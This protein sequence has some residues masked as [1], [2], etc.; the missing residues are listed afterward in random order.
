MK[1]KTSLMEQ[2]QSIKCEHLDEVL[3][4]RLGDFYEMFDEDAIEVSRLLNLTL[5]HR[6]DSPMCGV[7]HHAS[8][9]YI[10]RLLRLGKKIAICEQISLPKGGIG[11]AERKVTEIITPGTVLEEEYLD[12]GNHNFLAAVCLIKKMVSWAYIDISTGDFFATTW[13]NSDNCS[14]LEKELGRINPRE[15][16]ISK[17][18][19]EN[20]KVQQIIEQ[21][22]NVSISREDDWHFNF[23][24]SNQAL[25]K[26]FGTVNLRSFGLTESSTEA[27]AAGYLLEY[28]S[29]N[30]SYS[31]ATKI[32]PQVT[33]LSVYSDSDY[34]IIDDS[35]RRNLELTSNL[36]DGTIHYS[37]LE[38]VEY[39][40]TAMGKRMLRSFFMRPLK[41]I[42]QIKKRQQHI[43]LFIQNSRML[44]TIRNE[45]SKILD[46]ERLAGRIAM[47]RA[48]AKDIQAL[49]ISLE[50][51]IEMRRIILDFTGEFGNAFFAGEIDTAQLICTTIEKSILEDP[52]TS[53]TEGRLIKEGWSEEL[54]HYRNIKTH[55][56]QYL[57]SY[58]EEEK[59]A[60]GIQNMKVKYNNNMGY[61]LE[62]SKGK[63]TNVPSY[64]V[65]RR[66]LVNA[67]RYT[68]DKLRELESQLV[69]ADDKIVEL[70]KILFE[71]IRNKIGKHI[72]YLL[73]IA[74]EVAYIDTITALAWSARLYN[75]VC[76][77]IDASDS[78]EI[79][80]GRHP[81]VE[82]HL[83]SGKFVP[84][85]TSLDSANFI[86][87]TGP[88]MAGKSTYL[89]QN[90]LIVFLA[91]IGSFI[92]AKSAK[93]GIADRIF[94]RVGASD[95]LAR[96]ESTFL[97]EM[98]ETALILHSATKQSLVIMD[99]V[100]RGTST[101]DGLSIAWAISEY[102]LNSIGSRTFFA[103][104]YHELTRITHEHLQLLQMQVKEVA[105]EV[106]FLKK[107][108]KGAAESS[109]GL[110]VAKLAGIPLTVVDRATEILNIV[111]QKTPY[112]NLPK[113]ETKI[114]KSAKERPQA[115]APGLFS[116]EEMVLEEI[117]SAEIDTMTPLQALQL[118]ARLK[119]DLVGQK[120]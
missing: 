109:Y 72:K 86:L 113:T 22:S 28:V 89:R 106:V 63:L 66:A 50:R 57:E 64:F 9:L 74:R 91:Q 104:H 69:D 13:K 27:V 51:W 99:E 53:F 103:T 98:T 79:K 55:F 25:K 7:P 29:K 71:E 5:T 83:P 94:C 56:T 21:A 80:E 44:D 62:V 75:W 33:S 77:Q 6:G 48:H 97:V 102:L 40:K 34:V 112:T 43:A 42:E 73:L 3:F 101:E 116:E 87:L 14:E 70:E 105:G 76:P 32:L 96:G 8:K 90:A 107:I 12:Q 16:V 119:K 81:V 65:L 1:N 10:A 117:L 111:Q 17:N 39:T 84:N 26:Q 54:D 41:N 19:F 118:I 59:K 37:L 93:I 92:P 46:I 110:H 100:G 88:N 95:N 24:I 114:E 85:D 15:L 23:E 58:L 115:K 120:I 47:N 68:T 18:L 78:L 31:G 52:S 108:S 67:D 11:L 35:S 2:Y 82:A 60:T 45:L 4:F 49:K 20:T 38:C 30:T 61:Y 36:R